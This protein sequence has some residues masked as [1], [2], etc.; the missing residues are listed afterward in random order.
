MDFLKFVSIRR[1]IN[2]VQSIF[3]IEGSGWIGNVPD[4]IG[5]AIEEMGTGTEL[6]TTK[7]DLAVS[8]YKLLL[9]CSIEVLRGV[10][11]DDHFLLCKNHA[12]RN[13][14]LRE[15]SFPVSE[16]EWYKIIGNYIQT[17]FKE[18]T[19]TIYYDTV[20]LDKDG[21]PMVI[22]NPKM[23]QALRWKIISFLLLGGYKHPQ[24]NFEYADMRYSKLRDEVSND[25]KMP[26][27]EE[28]GI[29]LA[30]WMDV[31]PDFDN[32][33]FNTNHNSE[34]G[35]V[36]DNNVIVEKIITTEEIAK[37]LLDNE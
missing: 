18:G 2:S 5:E 31:R 26:R 24:F 25:M 9:P 29:V 19:V 33:L 22:D 32:G 27:P 36:V 35:T 7:R 15:N 3:K 34:E 12:F 14:T 4:W 8:E 23:I 10:Y 37:N 13:Q 1:V 20:P 30:G 17:S 6:K 28:I 11:Y 16:K 21:L